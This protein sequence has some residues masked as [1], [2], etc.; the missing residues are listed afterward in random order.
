MKQ[1]KQKIGAGIILISHNMALMSQV[2]D[3]IIVMY[4]GRIVE[5]GSV[6]KLMSDPK[7]PYT[8]GLI[9]SI[10]KISENRKRLNTIEGAV[11]NPFFKPSG[12]TF[13]PRCDKSTDICERKMPLIE[14][15]SD[16]RKVRCW[17]I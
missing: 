3:R 9:E 1:L 5:E 4:C 7:H 16:E 8:I 2:C 17:N 12:C 15:I 11:P 10:P 6:H 13:Q 14:K